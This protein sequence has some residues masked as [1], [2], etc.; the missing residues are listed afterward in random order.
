MAQDINQIGLKDLLEKTKLSDDDILIVED[1][2]NTKKV[3]FGKL[4]DSL[5]TD[6][7]LPSPHRI[8]SS[9]KVDDLMS[10]FQNQI[11][12][13]IDRVQHSVNYIT[14]NYISSKD[15]DKKIN[16][17]SEQVPELAETELIKTAL[18]SK[19]NESDAITCDDIE[20]GEDAKK[21]Q[22][23]N[24][25]TEVLSMMMGNTPVTP[26]AV[27]AGGWVNEDI[28]NESINSSKLQTQYR[29]RGYHATGNINN[30]T[31]DGL[32]LLGSGVSGLP[33]YDPDETDLERLLEVFNYG[34]NQSIIQKVY[35]TVE[36]EDEIRPVY[37]RKAQIGRLHVTN[38]VA[39]YPVTD[40]FK[41][42]R[43]ILEDNILDSG[44]ISSGNVFDITQDG[45]YLVKKGVKNLPNTNYDFTVSVR[46]YDTRIEYYAKAITYNAC[47]LYIC[48]S[49]LTSSGY[50]ERTEWYKTNTVE[51]SKLD[52]KR[53]HLFGDGVCCGLGS[54]DITTRSF[55]AL[56]STR[57]GLGI[58][59][60]ALGDATIGIYDDEYL[61]EIS[62]IKQIEEAQLA[63]GDLAIIFAGS[64]DYKYGIVN[65]GKT[66]TTNTTTFKGSLNT[67][68][69]KLLQK[70]SNIKILIASPIFRA[71]LDANDYRNSDETLI[72]GYYLRDYVTAMKEVA[73][74]NHIPFL[75]LHST[76]MINK[77]N[78]NN[79]LSDRLYLNDN[80]HDMMCNKIFSALDYF[81]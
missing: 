31:K 72:N 36:Q 47:E 35:Y 54:T 24:L 55:P 78:Y 12:I 7:E 30:F 75:D 16:E 46:K 2:E 44:I 48:N 43:N 67:A 56:L 5:I 59:N 74:Y 53:L 70:N 68:I 13:G 64:E 42:T 15:V 40:K 41:I 57:Y 62:V 17:F 58:I 11:D 45:D 66:N 80:G 81:Y 73:E 63:N 3:S 10:T 76:C 8:Y 9:H 71:R 51:K 4:R 77:Y 32:Y 29:Y 27:P 18:E 52:G 39:E 61:A 49:Y 50:R 65:M 1:T 6:D 14:E 28:A 21:I 33:K 23:R 60:H 19:R 38:F 79:Y 26:P 22:A 25:S 37:T 20:S 69:Q 34:P